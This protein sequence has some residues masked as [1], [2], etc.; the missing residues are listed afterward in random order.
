VTIDHVLV[1]RRVR[2]TGVSLHTIPGT[3]HR[4]LLATLVLPRAPG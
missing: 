4:A 1:D 3:D 2:V